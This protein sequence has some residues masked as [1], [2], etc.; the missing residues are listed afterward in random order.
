MNKKKIIISIIELL[1]MVLIILSLFKI[2]NWKKD[3]KE[4]KNLLDDL[5]SV[6]KIDNNKYIIDFNNLKKTNSDTIAYIKVNNT[7]IEYPVV[8][9]TDND[10]Y[11]NHNFEKKVNSGG[12][13]FAHYQNRFDGSDKNIVLFGHNMKDGSM[14]GTLKYTLKSDWQNNPDNLS[15]ILVTESAQYT[16]K[17]FSTYRIKNEEYYIRTN[18]NNDNEYLTFLNIIKNRSNYNYNID[19]TKDD[20]ILTLST[21]SSNNYRVVMHA[22]KVKENN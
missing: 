4:N 22:K 14:F 13:I 20:S 18:F 9:H 10:Y 16:Y 6:V 8:K 5:S 1:L 11:L 15:I 21:C 3:T 19:L 7:K 12:W 2:F 17:V